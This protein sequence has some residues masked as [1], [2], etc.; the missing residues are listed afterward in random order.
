[1]WNGVM[2]REWLR[3][4]NHERWIHGKEKHVNGNDGDDK[5]LNFPWGGTPHW[6]HLVGV[7]AAVNVHL[8]L[9]HEKNVFFL[10]Y[11]SLLFYFF[12]EFLLPLSPFDIVSTDM[13]HRFTILWC[14]KGGNISEDINVLCLYGPSTNTNKTL[15]HEKKR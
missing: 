2:W 10:S 1:M 9:A 15:I 5:G 3:K 11:M 13:L 12:S 14:T 6:L 7:T 4:W 8:L